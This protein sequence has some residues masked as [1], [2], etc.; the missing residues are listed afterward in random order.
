[1][2][3]DFRRLYELQEFKCVALHINWSFRAHFCSILNFS[4][5]LVI[6]TT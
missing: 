5:I 1:M 2:K 6:A 4:I 3:L